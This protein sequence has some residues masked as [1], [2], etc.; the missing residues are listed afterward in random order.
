MRE[1]NESE[2]VAQIFT[3]L[4]AEKKVALQMARQLTKRAEQRSR[5]ENISKTDALRELLEVAVYGAQGM[6]KP[7]DQA[8]L[9]PKND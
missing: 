7:S 1:E 4:G 6:L 5:N 3:N 9:E 2:Q 8:D